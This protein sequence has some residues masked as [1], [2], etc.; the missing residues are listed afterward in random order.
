MWPKTVAPPAVVWWSLEDG[1]TFWRIAAM[2][3][4]LWIPFPE[5]STTDM[6]E[7]Q[8]DICPEGTTGHLKCI[9]VEGSSFVAA[10][11]NNHL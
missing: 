10:I 6:K 1:H 7:N 2:Q 3:Q 5:Q 4:V 8:Q 9:E 11:N